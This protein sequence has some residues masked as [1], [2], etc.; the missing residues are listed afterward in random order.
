[1]SI[2]RNDVAA[3][4]AFILLQQFSPERYGRISDETWRKWA[5]VIVGLPRRAEIDKSPEIRRILTDALSYAPVEFVAAVRTIIRLERERMRAPGAPPPP[6]P[7][8]ILRD[9]DGCWLHPLLRKAI[10]DEMRNPDNSPAEYAAFLDALFDAGIDD[11]LDHALS[12][13]TESGPCAPARRL[14][15]TD[16]LLCRAPVR[17]WPTVWVAMESDDDFAREA[18][19]RVASRFGFDRPFYRGISER[20]VASLYA[21]IARLFPRNDKAERATGFIGTDASIAY[22]RDGIP[23]YLAELGT[24]AAVA[25]LSQLVAGHPQ[26]SHLAYELRAR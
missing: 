20:N 10:S 17:S 5:P 3:L 22:L 19:L 21:L 23:R 24:D 2:H 14:A 15:I 12:L 16:V 6:A 25:S 4:R 26:F 8:F 18:L 9:L 7:F 13:L 1:M 11:T